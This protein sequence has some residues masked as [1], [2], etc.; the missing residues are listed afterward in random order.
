MQSSRLFQSTLPRRER[1]RY[2]HSVPVPLQFQSTLP[3]R[4]RPNRSAGMTLGDYV[5]IHAPTKG[6]TLFI[7]LYSALN[8]VSIHAPTKGATKGKL[9][10]HSKKQVFQST[11]PRRERHGAARS[12]YR[13]GGFNP[14]SHEGSDMSV[15]AL[16]TPASGFNP[17][18]H[19]GSDHQDH[20]YRPHPGGFNPRSHEGS[21]KNGSSSA[22]VYIWFQSTLPRRERPMCA[23]ISFP[24]VTA[25]SIHAPTKGATFFLFRFVLPYMFQSTLPRRERQFSQCFV[26]LPNLGFNPRSHEGSD[27]I[28]S[29]I[30][31]AINVSIH[32]P[33]KGAT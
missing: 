5:S 18:S 33:T 12:I 25:V 13:M 17:R 15:P 4:E 1:L 22:E 11:L 20:G 26:I 8:L 27:D 23:S 14:R 24:I 2:Y 9:G 31:P 29:E 32:A 3:R 30:T 16:N 21:D 7:V 10:S 6:A 19:E 28:I